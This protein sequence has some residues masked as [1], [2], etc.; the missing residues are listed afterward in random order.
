M[1]LEVYWTDFSKMIAG[2]LDTIVFNTI[3]EKS[4]E[5]KTDETIPEPSEEQK[6]ETTEDIEEM[7]EN[8]CDCEYDNNEKFINYT[9]YVL[10]FLILFK[11]FLKNI[12]YI[13]K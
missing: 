5:E 11:F 1:E 3:L 4:A 6:E 13:I 10:I 12:K 8:D 7:Y 9:I 2:E